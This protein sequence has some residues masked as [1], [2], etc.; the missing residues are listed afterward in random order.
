MDR[1][2]L[3]RSFMVYP[4]HFSQQLG[5]ETELLNGTFGVKCYDL[6][7]GNKTCCVPKRGSLHAAAQ[8]HKRLHHASNAMCKAQGHKQLHGDT[9]TDFVTENKMIH[10]LYNH[11]DAAGRL[12]S[13]S[14]E[15]NIYLL[16]R[17]MRMPR[18]WSN[19]T[20][21]RTCVQSRKVPGPILL[22]GAGI[23]CRLYCKGRQVLCALRLLGPRHEVGK[24]VHVQ[25]PND[26]AGRLGHKIPQ[27]RVLGLQ[28]WV[29]Q[30]GEYPNRLDP[31]NPVYAEE[32]S[33][34]VIVNG[35]SERL[36]ASHIQRIRPHSE[37]LEGYRFL[38]VDLVTCH[39]TKG[40]ST[41]FGDSGPSPA[42]TTHSS[43]CG[44]SNPMHQGWPLLAIGDIG[45]LLTFAD[46][47]FC[48][49]RAILP[50]PCCSCRA[51]TCTL[52]T[53]EP[54]AQCRR[55]TMI[56]SGRTIPEAWLPKEPFHLTGY[57]C[58][59]IDAMEFTMGTKMATDSEIGPT[60]LCKCWDY[61]H[62][63]PVELA[64]ALFSDPCSTTGSTA[65]KPTEASSSS[66]PVLKYCNQKDPAPLLTDRSL[67]GPDWLLF[68]EHLFGGAEVFILVMMAYDRYAAIC[69]PLYY[70]TIMNRQKAATTL[71][72]IDG[73]A[74]PGFTWDWEQLTNPGM[75]RPKQGLFPL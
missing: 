47:S 60:K 11:F 36:R 1:A 70:L 41:M 43:T 33:P 17:P 35:F 59:A 67:G 54:N 49:W 25:V 65:N 40:R 51:D 10:N 4:V 75:T 3:I 52:P 50:S 39:I 23:Q 5:K 68:V 21:I 48:L 30:E 38:G 72:T 71:S 34:S 7:D 9:E 32:T 18:F 42:K 66:K 63:S 24:R 56:S 2:L 28:D 62:L 15:L 57:V 6:S 19:D 26:A 53:R 45:P 29:V 55:E 61:S 58:K 13:N 22:N 46:C 64:G 27:L 12:S 16:K 44:E 73:A 8:R 37:N 31:K 69:K 74:P 14:Y 20:Y